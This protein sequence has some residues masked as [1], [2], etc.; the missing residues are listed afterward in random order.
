MSG[1]LE[2][3]GEMAKVC[4]AGPRSQ[5]EPPGPC[6]AALRAGV[7][8][9]GPGSHSERPDNQ[10][11]DLRPDEAGRGEGGTAGT[12]VWDCPAK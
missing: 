12:E 11:Q 9:E 1:S 4:W 5:P 3:D 10:R 8:L 6:A 2:P 7:A